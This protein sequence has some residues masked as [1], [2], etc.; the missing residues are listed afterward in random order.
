[1][2]CLTSD[3]QQFP[4]IAFA[5]VDKS[6]TQELIDSTAQ[7]IAADKIDVIADQHQIPGAKPWIQTTTRRCDHQSLQT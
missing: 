5:E 1:L 3:L 6:R 7:R 2:A 4:V